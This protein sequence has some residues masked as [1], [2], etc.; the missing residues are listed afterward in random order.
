MFETKLAYQILTE[1]EFDYHATN[2][3]TTSQE[4]EIKN[5]IC[6]NLELSEENNIT[7]FDH[8][9]DY[10]TCYVDSSLSL[11]SKH[12]VDHI[13]K[14]DDQL[15][16]NFTENNQI[17]SGLVM[18]ENDDINDN[19]LTR[20][21]SELSLQSL[22]DGQ[23][24]RIT[25]A[26]TCTVKLPRD[27]TLT[28]HQQQNLEKAISAVYGYV[29][30]VYHKLPATYT[31][32]GSSRLPDEIFLTELDPNSIWYKIRKKLITNFD[33][34]IDKSWFSKLRAEE[35]TI[36]Q[37]LTLIAPTNFLR[38]WISSKYYWVIKQVAQELG[39]QFVELITKK[40]SSLNV[41]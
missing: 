38:D 17:K 31:K 13:D 11:D 5:D 12:D 1:G 37:K 10:S 16:I 20:G 40:Q 14:Y 29:K 22:S 24:A 32:L 9:A 30:I 8:I 4:L 36:T 6:Q 7:Q 15:S 3:Q 41:A 26:N 23:F 21:L 19:I 28:N 27:L 25:L 2:Y 39:Y 34:H 18:N 35:D 33:E